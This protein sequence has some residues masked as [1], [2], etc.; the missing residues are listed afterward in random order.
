MVGAGGSGSSSGTGLAS[1]Y[2][3]DVKEIEETR[4]QQQR[5]QDRLARQFGKSEIVLGLCFVMFGRSF[6]ASCKEASR[7]ASRSLLVLSQWP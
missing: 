4:K 2:F 1:N 3:Y 5:E 6:P 7:S